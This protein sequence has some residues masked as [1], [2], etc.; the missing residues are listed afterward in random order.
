MAED[1]IRVEPDPAS[2][3][4]IL[5]MAKEAAP[6]L[7]RSTTA[8]LRAA[9]E[10]AAQA[11]RDKVLSAPSSGG[12][13]WRQ[14]AVFTKSGRV[15]RN[16]KQAASKSSQY[17]GA[18]LRS[19]IAAGV[20]IALRTGGKAGTAGI[21]ITSGNTGLRADQ[22]RMN[23]TYA[24]LVFRHPVFGKGSVDQLGQP[25]WF[26]GPLNARHPE[27]EASVLAAMKIAAEGLAK[28]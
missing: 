3:R 18:G 8:L 11:S 1:L 27:F 9:A 20:G 24:K 28:L 22:Y 6:V 12:H 16:A 15:I 2:L 5:L 10:P 19:G 21:R 26:Y 25:D 7:R 14:R 13:T 4:K 23:R 17:R